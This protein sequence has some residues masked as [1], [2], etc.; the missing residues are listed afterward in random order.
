LLNVERRSSIIVRIIAVF[1]GVLGVPHV[2]QAVLGMRGNGDPRLLALEHLDV[3]IF[4]FVAAY[5]LWTGKRWAPWALAVAGGATALLVF[6]LGP[7]LALD[8]VAQKGLW[9]GA[10]SIAVMTAIGVWYVRRRSG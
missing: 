4:S 3:A 9:S 7:L 8:P 1:V 10:G 2:A 5:A 6:S